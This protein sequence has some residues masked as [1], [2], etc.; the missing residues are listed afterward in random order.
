VQLDIAGPAGR[1]EALLEE[2]LGDHRDAPRFAALVCHPHPRFGGTMH[3]HAAH[4]LA[5]AIRAQGGVA[6]RFNFRGVGRSAG[7]YDRGRGEADDARAALAWLARERPG[8]ARLS[9]GFSFG[10]WVALIAGGHDPGVRGLLLAGLALRSADLDVMRDTAQV[11]GIEKPIAIVQAA[12]DE[13]GT[14]DEVRLAIKRSRGPRWLGVVPRATHLFTEDLA[15]LQREA[16]A[17]LAWLLGEQ[18]DSDR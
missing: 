14:A 15:A 13:F 16:E 18:D 4:R 7:A 1:L 8:L 12:N 6:L 10:A 2:P 3:T 5:K 9:C 11:T 17:A